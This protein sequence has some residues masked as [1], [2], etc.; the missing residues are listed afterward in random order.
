MFPVFF[1]ALLFLLVMLLT[2]TI[3]WL[4]QRQ[5]R[6]ETTCQQLAETQQRLLKD[7]SGLCAAAVRMDERW[8]EQAR[9]LE[10]INGLAEEHWQQH[11]SAAE[12]S[13]QQAI[14]CIKQGIEME[15][16]SQTC[17]ITREEASLLLRLYGEESGKAIK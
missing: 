9:R 15:D 3:V 16:L 10:E 11:E 1:L 17:G 7:I 8:L 14:E 13:Y 5:R 4:W 2:G 12:P 6:L